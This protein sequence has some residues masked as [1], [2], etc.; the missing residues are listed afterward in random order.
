M[1]TF[2]MLFGPS[3]MIEALASL[4]NMALRTLLLC[5][6]W[7]RRKI[8]SRNLRLNIVPAM[9]SRTAGANIF[10]LFSGQNHIDHIDKCP[11]STNLT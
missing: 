2:S 1:L 10:I 11:R 8:S 9:S 6:G 5:S 4:S 3:L 7:C